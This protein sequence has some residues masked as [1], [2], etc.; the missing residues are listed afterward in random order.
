MEAKYYW[1]TEKSDQDKNHFAIKGYQKKKKERRK[2][3]SK[4]GKEETPGRYMLQ[5]RQTQAADVPSHTQ[6]I[7]PTVHVS[8]NPS[9]QCALQIVLLLLMR[10]WQN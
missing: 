5:R 6:R 1:P 3:H 8:L 2:Q 9:G 4:L 7:S 10:R